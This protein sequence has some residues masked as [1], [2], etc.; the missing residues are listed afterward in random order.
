[1]RYAC[2]HEQGSTAIEATMK[3]RQTN[4]WGDAALRTCSEGTVFPAVFIR[5]H[6]WSVLQVD[7]IH[8]HA[9]PANTTFRAKDP[10][11]CCSENVLLW[12]A[13]HLCLELRALV[14]FQIRYKLV[15]S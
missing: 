10:T 9:L 8:A 3:L 5:I 6:T 13:Q 12:Y 15:G 11:P 7:T 4:G 2:V 14:A 1:M